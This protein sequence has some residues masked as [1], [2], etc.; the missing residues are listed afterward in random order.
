MGREMTEGN[1]RVINER[2]GRRGIRAKRKG[3]LRLKIKRWMVS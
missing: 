3:R 1:K 2:V